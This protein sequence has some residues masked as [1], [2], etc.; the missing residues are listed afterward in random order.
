[1]TFVVLVGG[2]SIRGAISILSLHQPRKLKPMLPTLGS[3]YS[4]SCSRTLGYKVI[5]RVFEDI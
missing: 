3:S 4:Y 2:V 1:M 5:F